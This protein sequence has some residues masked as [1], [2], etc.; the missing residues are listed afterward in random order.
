MQKPKRKQSRSLTLR[1][2]VT[3]IVVML[4]LNLLSIISALRLTSTTR[5]SI[6]QEH[7]YL[8]TYY[9]KQLDRE[10]TQAQV[11]LY[12]MSRSYD[13]STALS[14]A[15]TGEAQYSALRSQVTLNTQMKDWLNQFPLVDGYFLFQPEGDLLIIAGDDSAAVQMIGEQLKSG[16][17]ADEQENRDGKWRLQQTPIGGV[18]IFMGIRRGIQYGAWVQTDRLLDTWGLNAQEYQ[19]L[20]DT[21]SPNAETVDAAAE[22]AQ[23]LLRYIPPEDAFALPLN[24]KILLVMSVT[25]LL[26]IPLIWLAMR[27]LVLN[28]LHEL[29]E[30]IRKIESG[31]TAYR[32]P[33]KTTSSE[34]ERL[35]TQFNRSVEQLAGMHMEIYEA[36]LENER[37]R[38]SY[39]TQQMQPHFV[40][41]TLNLIYSM[42]PEE[43]DLIQSTIM[44]LSNYYRYVAHITDPQVALGAE[45]NHVENYFKLQQTRYPGM[46]F[47][48]IECPENLREQ[49]IPPIVIQTF[50]ENTI[51]HSL[52]PGRENRIW[53]QIEETPEKQLHVLIRDS[54]NGYPPEVLAQIQCY[55]QTRKKQ[56]N[57]GMGIQNTI[58]RLRLIYKGQE[59]LCFS[60]QP[61]G[62][63]Q[64]DFYFPIREGGEHE[65]HRSVDF[66]LYS[67]LS[68]DAGAGGGHH[69]FDH[70]DGDV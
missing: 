50:A 56:P 66:T 6:L 13:F 20:P 18:L 58:E 7:S 10:L 45:L 62:G 16:E 41:N 2:A 44:C 14:G 51:K 34:F 54:G 37:T 27:R 21:V 55:Q 24:V 11:R 70:R 65:A 43:Y 19:I 12:S 15:E 53:I 36:Q 23:C 32:I 47:Y 59:K 63:A 42:E 49:M 35:N 9:T 69:G 3:V 61:Q 30:A 60:N 31:D 46:F 25:M 64:V 40:L 67:S 29:M 26:S 8:Q 1:L 39:L 52:I 38:V 17:Q 48:E 5:E 22:Q 4:T 33:E 57:L 28:P 68:P